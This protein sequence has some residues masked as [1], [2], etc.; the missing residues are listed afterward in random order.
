MLIYLTNFVDYCIAGAKNA[1]IKRIHSK[2]TLVFRIGK[3][4]GNSKKI[5]VC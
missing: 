1:D 3:I 4:F 2:E 5:K